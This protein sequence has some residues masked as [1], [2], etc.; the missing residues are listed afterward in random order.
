MSDIFH[1]C[2]NRPECSFWVKLSPKSYLQFDVGLS[3][4]G[5]VAAHVC[6]GAVFLQEAVP[7]HQDFPQP[8]QDLCVVW[9]LMLDQ[10]LGDVEQ[11]LRAGYTEGEEDLV[12]I[13]HV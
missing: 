9:Y 8:L 4:H 10:P 3:T 11:H 6:V 2:S 1:N 5:N 12:L 7:I 13:S